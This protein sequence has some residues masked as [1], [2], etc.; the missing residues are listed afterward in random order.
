MRAWLLALWL[1]PLRATPSLKRDRHVAI[2][3]IRPQKR[4]RHAVDGVLGLG[5]CRRYGSTKQQ[6]GSE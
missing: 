6:C 2:A 4:P 5:S 3:E 1:H